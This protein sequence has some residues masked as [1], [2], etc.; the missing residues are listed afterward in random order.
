MDRLKTILRV[1]GTAIAAIGVLC[2]PVGFGVSPKRDLDIFSNLADLGA[3]VHL[4]ITLVVLGLLALGLSRF[5]QSESEKS[6]LRP[7]RRP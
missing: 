4:G 2:L 3:F 1:G 5:I 7:Y 6:K